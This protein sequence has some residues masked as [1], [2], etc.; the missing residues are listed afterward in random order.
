MLIDKI[1]FKYIILKGEIALNEC[2]FKN[3]T[4]FD[5]GNLLLPLGYKYLPNNTS[6]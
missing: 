3:T 1:I 4:P 2:I 6:F 5:R